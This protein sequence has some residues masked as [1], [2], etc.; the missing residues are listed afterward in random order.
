MYWYPFAEQEEERASAQADAQAERT[1][2]DNDDARKFVGNLGEI[3]VEQFF[4]QFIDGHSWTYLNEEALD[5]AEP[6]YND[7]DFSLTGMDLDVKSTT[8]V[9]KFDP[10][11][12]IAAGGKRRS[13][14]GY[15]Q[16]EVENE[17]DVYVFVLIS[18]VPDP[19]PNWDGVEFDGSKD[20]A[21]SDWKQKQ[22]E[23][24]SGD[25]V[26]AILGWMFA[27]EASGE[28]AGNMNMSLGKFTRISLRDMYEL[29]F[30]SGAPME[31]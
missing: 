19:T 21:V 5:N 9:R 25:H 10:V 24:R 7:A 2:A 6:E 22:K 20:N 15:P 13:A 1:G 28:L 30:R 11:Q 27:E 16:V 12:M 17:S 3:A 18:S 31:R 23:E 4:E 14:S 29:V 8:D 26:A